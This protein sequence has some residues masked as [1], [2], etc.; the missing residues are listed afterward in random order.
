M[1]CMQVETIKLHM[2]FF[3]NMLWL[4]V[5]KT[6]SRSR[7]STPL[8]IRPS[9]I[10]KYQLLVVSSKA[11]K[12]ECTGLKPFWEPASKCLWVRYSYSCLK[13]T[14]SIILLTTGRIDIGLQL[15]GSDLISSF[16][17]GNNL[18]IFHSSGKYPHLMDRSI[19]GERRYIHTYIRHLYLS[20][21]LQSSSYSKYLRERRK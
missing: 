16:Y 18:E 6:F 8:I 15:L 7:K 5:S 21:Y 13:I 11:V 17:K 20:S 1:N 12:E 14:F 4:T 2:R 19:M 9:S 3:N 10:F